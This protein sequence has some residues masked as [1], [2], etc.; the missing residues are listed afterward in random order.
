M[1]RSAQSEKRSDTAQS[2][3]VTDAMADFRKSKILAQTDKSLQCFVVQ[4]AIFLSQFADPSCRLATFLNEPNAPGNIQIPKKAMQKIKRS[5]QQF[6]F[7]KKNGWIR[8]LAFSR[9]RDAIF[10]LFFGDI[11]ICFRWE[12]TR[13]TKISSGA[14]TSDKCKRS[15]QS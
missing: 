3:F 14:R 13:C 6:I 8:D 11:L 2:P 1:I 9:A 10:G 4:Y 12:Q 7:Q 15:S 5:I